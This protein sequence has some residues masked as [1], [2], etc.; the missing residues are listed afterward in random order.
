MS[1]NTTLPPRLVPRLVA[2]VLIKLTLLGGI[3]WWFVRDQRVEV[4]GAAAASQVL[5]AP[6]SEAMAAPESP[7]FTNSP[8]PTQ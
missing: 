1:S 3:W 6:L 4:D 2:A 8:E 7:T 5:G